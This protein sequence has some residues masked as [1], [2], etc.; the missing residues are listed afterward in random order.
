M[1]DKIKHKM[2]EKRLIHEAQI[3]HEKERIQNL[4]DS[5]ISWDFVVEMQRE[6]ESANGKRCFLKKYV[7]CSV[8]REDVW[9]NDEVEGVVISGDD[10]GKSV[11]LEQGVDFYERKRFRLWDTHD[12]VWYAYGQ[13]LMFSNQDINTVA[14]LNDYV[15]QYNNN[16]LEGKMQNISSKATIEE[17]NKL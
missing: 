11:I 10:F 12:Y 5:S 13:N 6:D 2:E 3:Q 15:N 1:F 14:E 17:E 7:V 8:K 9:D 4:L 16:L